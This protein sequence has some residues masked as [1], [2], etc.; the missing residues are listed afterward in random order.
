MARQF[1][2]TGEE[3]KTYVGVNRKIWEA[4]FIAIVSV[5]GEYDFWGMDAPNG[6]IEIAR[7]YKDQHL[8]VQGVKILVPFKES[9][10]L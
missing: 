5:Q 7:Y 8:E 3:P 10:P 4:P 1:V 2:V 6:V 9:D